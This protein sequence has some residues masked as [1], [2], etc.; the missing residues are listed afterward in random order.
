MMA[1]RLREVTPLKAKEL[2]NRPQPLRSVLRE[3]M[4]L[5]SALDGRIAEFADGGADPHQLATVLPELIQARDVFTLVELA[6]P[7]LLTEE[8]AKIVEALIEEQIEQ[9]DEALEALMAATVELPNYLQRVEAGAPDV[10]M[11]LLP[12]VNDLKAARGAQLLSEAAMLL[13][14]MRLPRDTGDRTVPNGRLEATVKVV[15][16]R[17]MRALLALLRGQEQDKAITVLAWSFKELRGASSLRST[18]MFWLIGRGLIDGLRAGTLQPSPAIKSILGQLDRCMKA[19]A[20]HGEVELSRA[21]PTSLLKNMLFYCGRAGDASDVLKLIRQRYQL[22]ALV[23]SEASIA[24]AKQRHS[25]PTPALVSAARESIDT[26]LSKI[27]DAIEAF[28]HNERA[29]KD[30]LLPLH[31]TASRLCDSLTVL[32]LSQSRNLLEKQVPLLQVIGDLNRRAAVPR[33]HQLAQVLLETERSID[34]EL[35][36]LQHH[37]DDLDASQEIDVEQSSLAT[38]P[39]EEW[40]EMVNTVCSE[41]LH[42]S[43]RFRD[44]FLLYIG[45]Q[46]ANAGLHAV[47]PQFRDA[48]GIVTVLPL[49]S[50]RDILARLADVTERRYLNAS[51]KPGTDEQRYIADTVASFELYLESLKNGELGGKAYLRVCFDALQQLEHLPVGTHSG[52]AEVAD[53]TAEHAAIN[54]ELLETFIDEAQEV[55]G[56]IE[57]NIQLWRDGENSNEALQ[58]LRRSFHTL[59]GSGRFVGAHQIGELGW[60]IENLLNHK[61]SQEDFGPDPQTLALLRE[62]LAALPTMVSSLVEPQLEQTGAHAVIE[63][64]NRI[65]ASSTPVASASFM[66]ASI[67]A[68]G[69]L[70][71]DLPR[72][73]RDAVLRDIFVRECR[74][75]LKAVQK[76]LADRTDSAGGL[77]PDETV[78]HLLHTLNGSA[79]TAQA[80]AVAVLVSPM[81]SLLAHYRES[82]RNVPAIEMAL[83][84]RSLASIDTS[85]KLIER[86]DVGDENAE[87]LVRELRG[88]L[89]QLDREREQNRGPIN[90]ELR[91]V[92]LE[93]AGD[94]LQTAERALTHWRDEPSSDEPQ[95]RFKRVL[96]TLKGSARMSGYQTLADVSHALESAIARAAQVSNKFS[97]NELGRYQEALDALNMCLDGLR[98]GDPVV[99]FDWLLAALDGKAPAQQTAPLV[100][101]AEMSAGSVDVDL[102]GSSDA[103]AGGAMIRPLEA[104]NSN[105]AEVDATGG[106]LL[107]VNASTMG[108]LIQRASEIN[109]LRATLADSQVEVQT[110][111]NEL[112]QTIKRMREQMRTLHYA[113]ETD[114]KVSSPDMD[115]TGFDPL[116]MDRYSRLQE[117]TRGLSESVGDL[118]ELQNGLR[119]QMRI[120]RATL[121]AQQSAGTD[122]QEQLLK[123]RLVRFDSLKNRLQRVVRQTAKSNDKQVKLVLEGGDALLDRVLL[124]NLTAPIEHILRNAIVHGI[125]LPQERTEAGKLAMGS[126]IVRAQQEGGDVKLRIVDDGAGLNIE[127]I[128]AV[129]EA[130]GL[131]EKGQPCDD[132]ELAQLLL[133]SGFSTAAEVTQD[134]G[135]GVGLDVVNRELKSAGG[136]LSIQSQRQVGTMFEL[137]LPQS[138]AIERVLLVRGGSDNFA[139]PL[140]TVAAVQHVAPEV[141]RNAY[142]NPSASFSYD[143]HNYRVQHLGE[144]LGVGDWIPNA[145]EDTVPLVLVDTGEQRVALHV[146][147]LVGRREIPVRPGGEQLRTMRTFNGASVLA[148][149]QVVLVLNIAGMLLERSGRVASVEVGDG[150]QVLSVID[151][152]LPTVMVVDDSIT[153]RKVTSRMLERNG[154]RVVTAR[155]GLE[156]LNA[157]RN[158]NPAVILLDL[159]MPRM[160][161]F[162]LAERLRQNEETREM[163]LI[164]ISSRTGHKH[165]ERARSLGVSEFFGKPYQEQKLLQSLASIVDEKTVG[166]DA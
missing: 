138:L 131:L 128:R 17:Y 43:A 141:V 81:E 159:E 28:V 118:D 100:R 44:A 112:S 111:L 149:G 139:L 38:L 126:V 78:T 9:R 115:A 153:I 47:L 109:I 161:G 75:H 136:A 12:L 92:F 107:R 14:D 49:P 166:A 164:V 67:E 155:D 151:E 35:D 55:T 39:R 127:K 103:L 124:G 144:M 54:D 66:E 82:H 157:L 130:K 108:Q 80:G 77:M 142:I 23:V 150:T 58:S 41:M 86:G 94:L 16:Q 52:L 64:A 137:R 4:A 18:R 83:I 37:G 10:P 154:Y 21:I 70:T 71:G 2:Q 163:P 87:R 101:A 140:K 3:L 33:L 143:G 46:T 5:L 102:D 76:H 105:F 113:A 74:S 68:A 48:V 156:A 36:A 62:A 15:R 8:M 57:E 146:D 152:S 97:D 106:D 32:G 61:I 56:D 45:P 88:I 25:V 60:S 99:D 50:A 134:A 69:D 65:S 51:I 1:S 79:R 63:K 7:Q 6:G 19:A 158:H 90:D 31:L 116:E 104:I 91:D 147:A 13:P 24:D 123:T 22:D 165:R 98:K 129:A 27:K 84:H 132:D 26:E 162:E 30:D 145:A 29:I 122:L 160:D 11:L 121:D 73:Q 85:L 120:N 42:L 148:D 133:V 96:H 89:G 20:K 119:R 34:V 125:E 110:Q 40:R 53:Q 59:K 114:L 135:R 117:I 72:F 93:E 95:E